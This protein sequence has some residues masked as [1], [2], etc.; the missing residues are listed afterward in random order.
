M[1]AT[2]RQLHPRPGKKHCVEPLEHVPATTPLRDAWG[3]AIP[4]S[5][6]TGGNPAVRTT[7][8]TSAH[9]LAESDEERGYYAFQRRAWSAFAPFY[10]ALTYL[11]LRTL[12][13]QVASMVSLGEGS[14]LLDVATGTGGQARA[15]ANKAHQVVGVDLSEAMLRIASRK[16][17]PPHV[18]FV[19][20]DAARLPFAD[21]TFNAA[22]VSFALHEMPASIRARV[23]HETA[24]V[25]TSGAPIIVVDYGL[26]TGRVARYLA[27]RAVKAYEGDPYARFMT[28]DL[29]SVLEHA[30]IRV[31]AQQVA[32]AG[33]ARI[34]LATRRPPAPAQ[35]DPAPAPADSAPSGKPSTR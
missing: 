26:P 2:R 29:G 21:A 9:A 14:R 19:V 16:H 18:A 17:R 6:T 11:P 23:L 10:D 4:G 1:R 20:A 15:F 32:L 34:W 5:T 35:D 3:N 8:G 28:T 25:T 31:T 30:G 27:Y 13:R 22:C 12:R 24:R 33:L 7:H